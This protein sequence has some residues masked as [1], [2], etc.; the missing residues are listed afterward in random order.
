MSY[1]PRTLPTRRGGSTGQPVPTVRSRERPALSETAHGSSEIRDP[2]VLPRYVEF[3]VK[4]VPP[5]A[6]AAV[7][8]TA[9]AELRH[10]TNKPRSTAS[11]GSCVAERRL[12]MGDAYPKP[13][14]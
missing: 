5:L 14:M 12:R 7:A 6:E 10:G 13:R 3:I 1:P 2:G 4:H 8:A 11:R 9:R